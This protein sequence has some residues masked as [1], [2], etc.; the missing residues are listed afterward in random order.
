MK[1]NNKLDEIIENKLWLGNFSAAEDINDLKNKK[2]K[3]ILTIMNEDCPKY[4]EED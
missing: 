3:K 4:K 1:K 2:I